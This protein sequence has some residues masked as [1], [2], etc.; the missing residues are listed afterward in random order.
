M[1]YLNTSSLSQL[2]TF[3]LGYRNKIINGNLDIWQ[4]ATS[5]AAAATGRYVADRWYMEG[6][7]SSVATDRANSTFT[8]GQT[9]V[10]NNPKYWY[11]SVVTSVSNVASFAI[12]RQGIEG[13]QT[14]AGQ[15][16]VLTFWAKADASKNIAVE[17][18]QVFG[19][20]G[21]PSATVLVAPTTCAL[22]TTWTKYTVPV[23]MPSISGKVLGSN[24]DDRVEIQFWFDAGSNYNARTNSLGNQSG[25][26]DIAQ[27]QFEP[28]PV[29]STFEQRAISLE[30]VLCQ[31]YS[32]VPP[33]GG[34][35]TRLA[36]SI[37][38][39]T[40][41]V[42]FALPMPT[43]MRA[44]PTASLSSV[45][46]WTLSD[47]VTP[48]ALST[49]ANFATVGSP[50]LAGFTATVASGLTQYRSYFFESSGTPALP[51]FSSDY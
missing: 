29:A 23:T 14:F 4:R 35:A 33:L 36:F 43:T 44:T 18:K 5:S 21:S 22:T 3:S 41:T 32:Y 7:I 1:S 34:A 6:N 9:D 12:L 40:T 13:V 39:S 19:T 10:P 25:T 20:G 45:T 28:G 50:N 26:F 48:T 47:G 49:F 46:G 37:A 15:T 51:V 27:V 11:R 30:Q 42:H 2:D 31:R 8:L 24:N 38:G 17:F 16:A